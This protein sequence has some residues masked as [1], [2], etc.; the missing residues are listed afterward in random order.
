MLEGEILSSIRLKK[1][2]ANDRWLSTLSYVA[3]ILEV[4]NELRLVIEGMNKLILQCL[5]TLTPF[6]N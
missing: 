5:A 3:N 4:P 2:P 1:H 6:R